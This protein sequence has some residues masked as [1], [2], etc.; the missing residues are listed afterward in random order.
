MEETWDRLTL[1]KGY[2]KA[3]IEGAVHTMWELLVQYDISISHA[4]IKALTHRL[5]H[6]LLANASC[7]ITEVT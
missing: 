1:L 5:N 4:S 7:R 6:C 3:S 2:I